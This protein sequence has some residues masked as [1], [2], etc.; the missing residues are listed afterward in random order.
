MYRSTAQQVFQQHQPLSR[1]QMYPAPALWL[2]A[3]HDYLGPMLSE[4]LAVTVKHQ[5]RRKLIRVHREWA[6]FTT[7]TL[8]NLQINLQKN[9]FI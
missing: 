7:T 9:V 6:H 8:E 5:Q 4:S 2:S 1:R 3:S